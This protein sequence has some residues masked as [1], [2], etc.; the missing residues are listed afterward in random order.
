MPPGFNPCLVEKIPC[1][2][3]SEKL[4]KEVI[5]RCLGKGAACVTANYKQVWDQAKFEKI[6]R[7]AATH[8]AYSGNC[9]DVN[10]I[11]SNLLFIRDTRSFELAFSRRYRARPA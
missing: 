8:K 5:E 4:C 2:I 1:E 11:A 6:T 3:L 9:G 10:E 7:N